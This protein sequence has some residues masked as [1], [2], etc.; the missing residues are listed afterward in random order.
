MNPINYRE[1]NMDWG[2]IGWAA[3]FG[4]VGG[5]LGALV[6]KWA[7]QKFNK[8]S[9]Y[10][11]FATIFVVGA[12][13]MKPWI[14]GPSQ[15]S[16][17]DAEKAVDELLHIDLFT[18]ILADHPEKR[19]YYRSRLLEAYINGGPAKFAN[20]SA[21]MGQEIDGGCG[22]IGSG[23]GSQVEGLGIMGLLLA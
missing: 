1:G 14:I 8:P 19:S 5:G 16:A 3:L 11:I 10:I 15:P 4:A 2:S 21:L 22:A 17:T 12:V 13:G 18:I 7:A 6:G 20:A 9:L 23:Y